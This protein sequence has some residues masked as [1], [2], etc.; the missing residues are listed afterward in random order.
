VAAH[1]EAMQALQSAA[2]ER[3]EAERQRLNLRL[4]QV[5]EQVSTL[6]VKACGAAGARLA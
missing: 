4:A 1:G 3:V 2:D 5:E 6:K